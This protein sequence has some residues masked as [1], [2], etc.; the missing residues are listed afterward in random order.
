MNTSALLHLETINLFNLLY[1]EEVSTPADKRDFKKYK[2]GEF[3]YIPNDSSTHV[4]LIVDGRVKLGRFDSE[5]NEIVK[6]ILTKGEIFGE[7]GLAGEDKRNDFAV[8]VIE[9]H[10]VPVSI[11]NIQQLM[12][13][14]REVS[15]KIL[16][17]LGLRLMEIERK[18]ELL[19]FKDA[20]TRIVEFLKDAA[21]SVGKKVGFEIAIFTR[22]THKDIADLTGTS[23]QTVTGILNEL[24]QKNAIN[25][26]RKRILI[27]DLNTLK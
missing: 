26:D 25:F 27:R 22:L 9:S 19:V 16:K 21:V 1:P 10:I 23:R 5:G 15:F 20:R 11:G 2:K 24:K 8:A 7:L 14:D 18:V 12:Q 6:S 4:Y 17:L 3:I 13:K